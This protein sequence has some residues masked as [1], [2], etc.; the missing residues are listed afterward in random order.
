MPP[1]AFLAPGHV[2]GDVERFLAG[3]GRLFA[4]FPSPYAVLEKPAP[5]ER[6]VTVS[7]F[8][9]AWGAACS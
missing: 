8:V 1:P 6:S 5:S 9:T 3:K 4:V 2:P 7:D